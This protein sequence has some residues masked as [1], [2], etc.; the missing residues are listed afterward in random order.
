MTRPR[1][2]ALVAAVA[3]ALP[4]AADVKP[5][6]LFGYHIVLQ[7][8]MPLPIWGTAEPGEEV[9][10]HLEIKTADGKREEGQA[11]KADKD[12][13]WMAKLGAFPAGTDGVLTVRGAERVRPAKKDP[14]AKD[15]PNAVAFKNVAVGEVWIASGQA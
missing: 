7:R 14:K 1:F 10:V 6:A 3:F 5:H 12:G 9:Y 11:V 15:K 4:A 13:K 2:I 8:D